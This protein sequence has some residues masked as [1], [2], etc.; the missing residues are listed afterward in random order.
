MV[1]PMGRVAEP[2]EMAGPITFLCSDM[3]SYVNGAVLTA[4]GTLTRMSRASA[5]VARRGALGQ[6]LDRRAAHPRGGDGR[7]R[8]RMLRRW[9][10]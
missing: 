8:G 6:R 7:L 9:L 10:Q 4:D 1:I 5:Q 3:A 2:W